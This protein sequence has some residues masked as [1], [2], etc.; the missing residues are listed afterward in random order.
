MI[1][2]NKEECDCTDFVD[3]TCIACG[4]TYLKSSVS[5]YRAL[6]EMGKKIKAC[7]IVDIDYD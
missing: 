7:K 1:T 3:Q 5:F 2:E 6:K 4:K